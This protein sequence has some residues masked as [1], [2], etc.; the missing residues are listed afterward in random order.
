MTIIIIINSSPHTHPLGT[1]RSNARPRHHTLALG[2]SLHGPGPGPGPG[3]GAGTAVPAG[4]G[5]TGRGSG[6]GGGCCSPWPPRRPAEPRARREGGRLCRQATCGRSGGEAGASRGGA[7][8]GE[9]KAGAA[10]VSPQGACVLPLRTCLS[11]SF[12][13]GL[14]AVPPP[15]CGGCSGKRGFA[16]LECS[17]APGAE[18]GDPATG[19]SHCGGRW[20]CGSVPTRTLWH[21]A[22]PRTAGR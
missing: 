2:R 17:A 13:R 6:A 22:K 20:Q 15:G 7:A 3:E 11:C 21:C 4:Q 16:R 18:R 12:L 14:E 8:R 9:R 5:R 1:R 19:R 10:A